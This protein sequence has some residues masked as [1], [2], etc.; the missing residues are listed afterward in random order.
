[1]RDYLF[2]KTAD[3]RI[4]ATF[5]L[6]LGYCSAAL[7][8]EVRYLLPS[9]PSVSLIYPNATWLPGPYQK[10][11]EGQTTEEV[12]EL[13][14]RDSLEND[15]IDYDSVEVSSIPYPVRQYSISIQSDDPNAA[16][17]REAHPAFVR[18]NLQALT[19]VNKCKATPGCW[20]KNN[21][22]SD[23]PWAIFPQF[24]LPMAMQKSVLMLNYPPTTALTAKNYL[25]TFTMKR[26]SGLMTTVG[27]ENPV[28]F[29]TIVDVRPIAAPGSGTSA[30]LPDAQTYFND[31]LRKSGGYYITPQLGTMLNPPSNTNNQRTL[32]LV[33]LGGPARYEWHKITNLSDAVLTTGV[34]RLGTESGKETPFIL[35]N[36]PDV[37]TYQC[38]PGD[39]SSECTSD[40]LIEMEEI[41]FQVACWAQSMSDSPDQ[42][43]SEALEH[44]KESW[45][46]DRSADDDLKFCAQARID[47]NEC[48]GKDI[49]WQTAI[50]YCKA[51]DNNACA[52]YTCPST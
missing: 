42:D 8:A 6:A 31:P 16:Y 35:G 12:I 13:F 29:E 51:N 50:N 39:T 32:P 2:C 37:T 21:P 1:M 36:H 17:Y 47:S 7:C 5:T 40:H 19:G 20:N 48:F 9:D 43:P 15:G 45:V 24:G 46:T 3:M 10:Y 44:C 52:T 22:H 25:D 14:T 41:D 34:E 11:Y 30:N 49:D 28:L 18:N 33:V 26:W 38:C 27:I 23:K 4:L